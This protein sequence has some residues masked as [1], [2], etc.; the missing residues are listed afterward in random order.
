MARRVGKFEEANGGTLLLDEISEMDLRLQ[1][2]LLR[3]IQE[4]EIDRVGGS[5]PVKVDIRR[6]RDHQPRPDASVATARSAKTCYF[7][8]NVVNLRLPPLRERPATSPPWPSTS[9]KK[10]AAAN[11]MPDRAAVG[12]ARAAA[13][14]I[15]WRGNVRELENTMHRAVL[16]AVATGDRGF[17]HPPAGRRADACGA[18]HAARRLQPPK[19]PTRLVGRTVADV[20]RDLILD[21]LSHTARQPHPCGDHP[22]DLDPDPAQQAEGICRSRRPGAAAAGRGQRG[23]SPTP[24]S[25]AA[26]HI[27]RCTGRSAA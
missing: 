16:L 1:A 19:P 5:Q 17:A 23:L 25:D 20:E 3:A 10:Y 24:M 18:S 2:K 11:G 6:D 26:L 8:L 7:R 14:A 22:R 9:P 27:A 4:R 13:R 12:V 15:R 21:T